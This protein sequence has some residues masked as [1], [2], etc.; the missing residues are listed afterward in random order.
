MYVVFKEC[1]G[2][3]IHAVSHPG[4]KLNRWNNC[5][6]R[7]MALEESVIITGN[8]G[9]HMNNVHLILRSYSQ[10]DETEGQTVIHTS[11]SIQSVEAGKIVM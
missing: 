11:V 3:L 9:R 8:V 5:S 4:E 6:N 1:G 10:A 2:E 7:S